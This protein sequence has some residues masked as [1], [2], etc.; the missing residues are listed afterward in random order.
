M[1]F[2]KAFVNSH[3]LLKAVLQ[4]SLIL[5]PLINLATRP[6]YDHDGMR[7]Y[8]KNTD[9][10]QDDRFLRAYRAGMDS[11][12]KIG[13]RKGS[14]ADIHI[15]WR[16]HIA[17]WAACHAARLDGDFVECGVNTGIFSL[18]ICNYI[19]FNATGKYFY[20]FDT[21]CGIP[22]EQ[23]LDAERPFRTVENKS[24]YEECYETARR[25]FEPFQRARLVRGK[26]PDTLGDVS[27]E[28]VCY[29]H[30]DMNIASYN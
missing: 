23:M 10:L 1:N 19:D 13:R 18:A 25:N 29:L 24:Y 16:V 4:R 11:G 28:K 22:E 14:Q 30:I 2:I 3:P 27:I 17:I 26:V 5:Q 6:A 15:E 21:F 8:G 7:L 9:F 20:L 12:H